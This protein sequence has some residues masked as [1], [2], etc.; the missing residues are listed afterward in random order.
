MT[1]RIVTRRELS[2]STPYHPAHSTVI[3]G[4]SNIKGGDDRFYNNVFVGAGVSSAEG[5]PQRGGYGLWVYDTREFPI[6]TGGNVFYYGA[7]PSAGESGRREEARMNPG[8]Q[9]VEDQNSVYL[10]MTLEQ[11]VQQTDAGVITT[12]ILGKARIPGLP[13]ENRDG[14]SLLIDADYFGKIRDRSLPTP[15]PFERPGTGR[16]RVRI[17][18]R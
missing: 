12:A 16:L 1:G 6:H 15:G 5:D 14:S 4:L 2:R 13:Y 11:S 3:A 17:W 9:V 10:L 18:P 8:I 7:R